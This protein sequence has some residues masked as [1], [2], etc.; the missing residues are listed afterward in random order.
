MGRQIYYDK[1]TAYGCYNAPTARP[2]PS[3]PIAPG[4]APWLNRHYPTHAD[5]P[6]F[7]S[8]TSVPPRASAGMP[9]CRFIFI[10][11]VITDIRGIDISWLTA[12]LSR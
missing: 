7:T 8:C 6:V 12:L 4:P 9:M 5:A 11:V 2:R 1:C 3:R 10:D